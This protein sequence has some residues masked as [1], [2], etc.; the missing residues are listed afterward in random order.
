MDI[1][2]GSAVPASIEM[3]G[4]Q[5][6]HAATV[7]IITQGVTYGAGPP[8]TLSTIGPDSPDTEQTCKLW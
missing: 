7:L 6:S 3:S 8:D 5:V 1:K 2:I 4:G